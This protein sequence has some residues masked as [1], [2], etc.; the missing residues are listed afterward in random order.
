MPTSRILRTVQTRRDQLHAYRFQNRRA[1]A[2]LVTGEPNV[3]EPPMRRLTVVTISGIM[4]AILIACGFALVGVF[5]PSTGD[6]W[7]QAGAI[8]VE[9]QTGARYV[10]VDGVLHPVLNYSSAVLAVGTKQSPHV[11]LVD[12]SDLASAKR[13][14]TIGIDGIPDSLPSAGNLV[15]GP[16]TV[17][18]RQQTGRADAL[19][20]QVSVLVGGDAGSRRLPAST[21]VLVRAASGGTRYLLVG[22]QRLEVGSD[23]VVTSLGLPTNDYLTVGTA[24]LDGVPS[25][26]RLQAP[27]VPHAGDPGPRIGGRP[28]VVGQLLYTTDTKRY[29]LT[30][31]DGTAQLD[32]VQTALLRT[33]GVG[34]E[35]RPVAQVDTDASSVLGAG[36]STADWAVVADQLKNLPTRIPDIAAAPA[37]NGGICA[38]YR[39]DAATPDLAVPPSRLPAFASGQ[40]AESGRSQR[41]QADEVVLRPGQAAVARSS[42]GAATLFVVAEPGKKYA[43]ASPDVLAGFGYAGRTPSTAPFELLPLIPTGRALDPVAARRPA[44][45]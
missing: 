35:H 34:P 26:T 24:F 1:L 7:K 15:G 8:I 17:C 41:G 40:V 37:R 4:I 38:V 5:R 28:T 20:A 3:L 14:P 25:G 30:L 39:G 32:A 2:A 19:T 29:Y 44:S 45:N 31:A 10:L 43:V 16:W 13:G 18:S 27:N 22:G 12:R 36:N 11:V 33:L 21:G 9:R 6:E 23:A 42:G